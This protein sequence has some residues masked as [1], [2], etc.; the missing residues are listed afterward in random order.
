LRG[1][2]GK[3]KSIGRLRVDEA[4]GKFDATYRKL[5]GLIVREAAL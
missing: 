1:A 3:E 5:Q 2:R 4:S